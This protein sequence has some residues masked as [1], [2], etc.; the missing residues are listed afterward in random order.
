MPRGTVDSAVQHIQERWWKILCEVGVAAAIITCA[1]RLSASATYAVW[2]VISLFFLALLQAAFSAF[3]SRTRASYIFTEIILSFATIFSFFDLFLYGPEV[4]SVWLVSCL[5]AVLSIYAYSTLRNAALVT[6]IHVELLLMSLIVVLSVP[7]VQNLLAPQQ[8]PNASF[9]P[10]QIVNSYGPVGSVQKERYELVVQGTDETK[11]GATTKWKN[12]EFECKP[13]NLWRRPCFAAPYHH[14]LDWLMTMLSAEDKTTAMEHHGWLPRFLQKLLRNNSSVTSLLEHNPFAGKDPP[15][16][17][18]VLRAHFRF[19]SSKDRGIFSSGPWWEVA[20]GMTQV[21]IEP[22]EV[23]G[24]EEHLR[25]LVE[26]RTRRRKEEELR[27]KAEEE[28][29]RKAAEETELQRRLEAARQA[30]TKAKKQQ[31][32][33]ERMRREEELRRKQAEEEKRKEQVE[34]KEGLKKKAQEEA[35]AEKRRE[36]EEAAAK[37]EEAKAKAE[38]ALRQKKHE[39]EEMQKQKEAREQAEKEAREKELERQRVE[40]EKVKRE[41]MLRVAREAQRQQQEEDRKH[42]K[43]AE[44][45]MKRQEEERRRVEEEA[46]RREEEM[47]RAKEKQEA[48]NTPEVQRARFFTVVQNHKLGGVPLRE[49][50]ALSRKKSHLRRRP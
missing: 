19:A 26:E 44:E 10:F 36:E 30:A 34:R 28:A 41:E 11:L 24:A 16:H 40:A 47:G 18:R 49:A 13:T 9:E 2:E 33:A 1:M 35:E 5:I 3:V 50:P 17:V 8:I 27:L 32:E 12:Y 7:V 46:R 4:W 22:Q 21:Y 43:E 45:A 15:A 14:H 23:P 37:A 29:R 6:K 31:E 39:E 20:K 38:A 25:K 42:Q 48:Q